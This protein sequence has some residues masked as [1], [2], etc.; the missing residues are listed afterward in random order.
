[1]SVPTETRNATLGEL[2]ETLKAQKGEQLD[3]VVPA[4]KIRSE[5]GLFL[6]EGGEPILTENGV[7]TREDLFKATDVFDE[8]LSAKLGIPR[9]YLKRMRADR[10]DLYDT[11]VN[12]WLKGFG[13]E[14]GPDPRKFLVRA[15]KGDPGV[16]RAFLSDSFGILDNYDALVAAL[17]GVRKAGVDVQINRCDLSDRRMYVTVEAPQV[18]ALAPALLRNYR[19]PFTGQQGADNPVV[20][21]GFR[22]S[23][24]EVGQGRWTIAPYLT[25]LVCRNGMT[26]TQDAIGRSHLGSKM[27]EGVVTWS[28]ETQRKELELITSQTADIVHTCLN[29]DYIEAKIAEIEQD[30][31][32]E[33]KA[34]DQVVKNVTKAL[35]FSEEVS[36]S[37]FDFFI[38][39]ADVTA[40]G[41]MQAVTAAAQ[42]VKDPDTAAEME[43]KALA[44]LSL[45]AAA[46][47]KA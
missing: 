24:S 42:V 12:G 25:V 4:T 3:L 39:G 20:S 32:V 13:D 28:L 26:M 22:I 16:A 46:G 5:N 21:A 18:Q 15:F 27:D 11:N 34:A 19:S 10:I 33:L 6:I 17:S 40:G 35:K 47:R 30:S 37:V 2:V 43:D 7:T 31:T 9:N 8:G 1:M 41:V 23:N 14:V 38:R 45:A 36:E 44:A 29:V